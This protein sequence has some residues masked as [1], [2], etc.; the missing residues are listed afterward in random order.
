MVMD[1]SSEFDLPDRVMAGH[2]LYALYARARWSDSLFPTKW[3]L[4]EDEEGGGYFQAD[5]LVSKTSTTAEKRTRF[6]P[7]TGPLKGI[8]TSSWFENWLQLR[9]QAELQDPDGKHP[10]ITSIRLDGAFSKTKLSTSDASSWLRDLLK[11]GNF[12]AEQRDQVSSHSLKAT[13]LSWCAKYGLNLATR[14]VLGY[15]ASAANT[16]AAHYSRDE[17]AAPLRAFEEVLE[18]IREGR[19]RPDQ[20]RSGYMRPTPKAAVRLENIPRVPDERGTIEVVEQSDSEQQSDQES[21]SSSSGEDSDLETLA[22]EVDKHRP[23]AAEASKRRRT[24]AARTNLYLHNRWK[25]LHCE[26]EQ[27]DFKLKC[28]RAITHLYRIIHS[29]PTFDYRKCLDCFRQNE[30]EFPVE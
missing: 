30:P 7:L 8:T 18:A 23:E 27:F 29:M 26:H 28:G 6:L 5:T 16:S 2:A 24:D 1:E 20:T 10:L 21:A 14:Q 4:D 19:F 12:K 11:L 9:K 13:P 3:E 25:T 22:R 15:H 17:L